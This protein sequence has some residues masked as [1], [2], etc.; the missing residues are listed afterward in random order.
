MSPK[1]RRVGAREIE[2]TLRKHDF[3]LVGQR[4]SHRK[5]RQPKLGLQVIVPLHK[6]KVLPIGT[7]RNILEAARIPEDEW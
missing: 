6:G 5:W 4:G 2:Q 7:L 1:I 3:E